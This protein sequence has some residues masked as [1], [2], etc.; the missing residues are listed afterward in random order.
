M[1]RNFDELILDLDNNPVRN[2][3]S[4]D[5]IARVIAAMWPKFSP[6]LQAE[7]NAALEKEV[8]KPLTLAAACVGALMGAYQG[9]ENMD[10]MMRLTRMELA[11]KIHKGGV[12]EIEPKDR[13]LIKS[14]LKKRWT[15]ILIPV[16]A[17]EMLE[18]DASEPL[19]T[20]G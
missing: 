20:V 1:K 7:L 15:G 10:D 2:G 12:Q 3:P 11:R 4:P 8:G 6:E 9:E 14:L 19:K 17:A 5:A 18:K 13:D 16:V